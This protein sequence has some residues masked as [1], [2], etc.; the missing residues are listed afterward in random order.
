MPAKRK[1]LNIG[2]TIGDP[3]GIGPEVALK[4]L[5]EIHDPALRFVLIGRKKVLETLYGDILPDHVTASGIIL[6]DP[7]PDLPVLCDVNCAYPVPE[8]GQASA[9]TGAESKLYIDTALELWKAGN[10][11]AIVTGPVHKGF[12]E[13]SGVPFTGHTEYMAD[14]IGEKFPFM[15]MFSPKYRVLLATTHVPLESAVRLV[16]KE[17]LLQVISAGFKSIKAIDG[18]NVR[19]AVAGLD[20]HCGD[21]GAIGTFDMRITKKAVEEARAQGIPVDGPFSADT[22][23]MPEKWA[24][25]NLVIVHY[26]DQGLIPFK[27]L[28]FDEGVNVTMGLSLIRTSVDHGTALDIAGKGIAKYSSMVEAIHLAASLAAV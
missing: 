14:Y 1:T 12:I 4:A 17:R 20:P 15:M 21:D 7:M 2:I 24:A 28:A 16:T 18:G 11:S 25:Y 8:P 19:L 26:H 10:I 9:L 6:P 22:L 27:I 23:F 5:R 3:A 13:K